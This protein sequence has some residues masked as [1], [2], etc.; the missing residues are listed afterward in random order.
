V[1]PAIGDNPG[2]R[3]SSAASV[4]IR[5]QIVGTAQ[6]VEKVSATGDNHGYFHGFVSYCGVMHDLNSL[7]RA[8]GW[9]I[10]EAVAINDWG[11]I[12]CQAVILTPNEILP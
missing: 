4:N 2:A 9:E 11:Q 7:I 3:F 8:K 5:G 12:A 10:I 1:L 6:Q